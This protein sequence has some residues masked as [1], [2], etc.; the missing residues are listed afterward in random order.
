METR[1][2]LFVL[3]LLSLFSARSTVWAEESEEFVDVDLAASH[4]NTDADAAA[5]KERA[6]S[7][8][9][10]S[11][12]ELKVIEQTR[13]NH[14]FEAEVNKLMGI[15]I[16]SLYSEAEIFLRELISNASDALDKIRYAAITDKSVLDS[17]PVLDIKIKADA[18][19]KTLT[20][21]DSGVGMGRDELVK[22]LGTIAQS[23]TANF[24]KSASSDADL[25]LI[26]QFGVGFYSAFLVADRVEVH[27]KS[28]KSDKQYVWDASSQSSF[29]V[30]EDPKQDLGRGTSIVLHI[31]ESSL[32]YL[33]ESRLRGLISQYSEFIDFPIYLWASHEEEIPVEEAADDDDDDDLDV[34][35]IED[36]EESAEPEKVTVWDYERVNDLKPL[37][38][39]KPADVTEE[40]YINFY[41]AFSKDNNDPLAHEHFSAEGDINFRGLLYIPSR[42]PP[43]LYD[44]SHKKTDMKLYVKKVFITDDFTE[45]LPRYLTFVLGIVDSDDLPL[46]VSREMLQKN[47]LLTAMKK[48]LVRKAIAMIQDMAKN[49]EDKYLDFFEKFGSS[50]KLGILEDP[51]NKARL[52]KLLRFQSSATDGYTSMEDYVDRMKEGQEQIYYYAAQDEKE[53]MMKSPLLERLLSKGYEVLFMAD[54]I[55]EYIFQENVGIDKFDGKEVVN[56]AKDGAVKLPE[57]EEEEDSVEELEKEEDWQTLIGYVKQIIAG[58]ISKV[59]LTD[60]LTS[61]PSIVSTPQ[62]G[63]TGNME[64]LTKAQ[65]LGQAQDKGMQKFYRSMKTLELNPYHPIVLELKNRVVAG[66]AS[67]QL[68]EITNLLFESAMLSSGYELE[69][70]PAFADRINNV[71]RL[72]L[73][74]EVTYPE[75]PEPAAEE[76]DDVEAFNFDEL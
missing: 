63:L 45:I 49:D 56:V 72:G 76:F 34:E 3:C 6:S 20:I 33:K 75:V 18:E 31:K 22:N 25:G 36:D 61:S 66:E 29:T 47:K 38:A 14:S 59:K 52:E 57:D 42:P 71:L 43:S 70:Q 24:I 4:G 12:E 9:A 50:I 68:V 7:D 2:F 65:S 5:H 23:G 30:Y 67:G 27:S 13:E 28:N 54:P 41:K 44:V 48:K 35:D 51:A 40:E 8:T 32:E 58:K 46:N 21:T 16:N 19:A 1:L 60:R 55:D 17:N 10:Y 37:W 64:K 73:G 53:N 11:A 74:L 15:I 26:G 69:D 39:R 62:Y